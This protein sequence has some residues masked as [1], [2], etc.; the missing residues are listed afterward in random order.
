MRGDVLDL[1][2]IEPSQRDRVGAKAANLAKLARIGAVRVP[3]AFCVT[4]D[5]YDRA[6]A[7]SPSIGRLLERLSQRG[8]EDMAELRAVCAE[9][10]AAFEAMVLPDDLVESIDRA[11]ARLGAEAAW[12]V[13]SSA[14]A[15]DQPT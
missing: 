8:P 9:I 1:Q 14:T 15:E 10:R 11:V 4:T 12:A 7:G 6:L 5:A 2:A 13:R 3:T